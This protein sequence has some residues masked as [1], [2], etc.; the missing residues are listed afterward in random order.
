MAAF[1]AVLAALPAFIQALPY[2]F[3]VTLKIMTL[4][5]KFI[6]WSQKQEFNKFLS[7]CEATIDKLSAAK[8]PEEKQD[9]AKS[10]VDL[11]RTL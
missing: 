4:T 10:M 9:A 2:I 3:Q 7:D 8:T 1:L 5:E 11:L 6:Q